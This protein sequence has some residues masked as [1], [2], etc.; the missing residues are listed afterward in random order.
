MPVRQPTI[1]FLS[2][3]GLAIAG[4]GSSASDHRPVPPGEDSPSFE[5]TVRPFLE[6][7]CLACHS[8]R[9]RKGGLDLE[10]YDS[11]E[12]VTAD[13]DRWEEV[14][15]KVG[16]GEMPPEDEEPRPEPAD[17]Q[18]LTAFVS[19]EIARADAARAADP[20]RVI[21][22]RLNRTEYNN[23]VRDLLGLDLH[24]ADAFPHDD[25]GYGFDNIGDVLSLSPILMEK[26]L[27]AAET[28]ART[29]I[30]GPEAQKPSL[31]KLP[32]LT[33]R[34]QDSPD[35]PA[36]Y[37]ATGLGLPNAVHATH[38]V[39][40]GG[41]YVVRFNLGGRRPVGSA[42]VRFAL[43]I[44]GVQ[45]AAESVDPEGGATFEPDHQEF[46]GRRLEFRVPLAAGEHWIA[47]TVLNLYE[48]LPPSYGGPVPSTRPIPPP[49]PRFK[50]K[51]PAN[52]VR[53]GS[54]ELI[55]PYAARTGPSAA[56]LEAVYTCGHVD[57]RHSGRCRTKI[58][59]SLARRAFRRPVTQAEVDRFTSIAL[60]G[61]RTNGTFEEGL[62]VA[63]QAIL[64]APD[65][66][67]RIERGEPVPAGRA[68]EAVP[69][70]PHELATRLAYFLWAS[71]PD[72]ALTAAADRRTL[73]DPAVLAQQVRRMLRDPR[74]AA[75][76]EHFGG[77]WLQVRA[78]ESTSPDRER[79]PDFDHYLRLSMRRETEL[80][81]D[82]IVREDRSVLDFL[83]GGYTFVNERLARHYGLEGVEGPQF[84]RVP[85]P[86]TGPRGGLL[87]H[88]SILTVSSYATRTSPVLRGKWILENLLATPPP[89]PP[90]DVPNLDEKAVGTAASLRQQLEAHRADPTCASCHKRMDPLGFGL[91]NFDAVGAW[92]TTD[93][94]F[95]VDASG[96]L[97]DGRS[98]SGPAELRR[99]L[100]ADQDAFVRA[101]AGKL[102]TY[103]LGR[104]LERSDRHRIRTIADAVA[105]DDYRFS[106]LVLGIVSSPAFQARRAD[107]SPA[108]A[109]AAGSDSSHTGS[110]P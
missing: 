16:A 31:V 37:D 70:T 58:V 104:G 8:S 20:G 64:V 5:T 45:V 73:R 34:V 41:E 11:I 72:E 78:L 90:P 60:A 35:V 81:F 99:I 83:D 1:V 13:A 38:R 17:V 106:S 80:F 39:T 76:A 21:T 49:S 84:R 88:A 50:G 97:P 15:R 108:V 43:W 89:E 109:A 63:I 25:S 67:F 87:G 94:A 101:L 92:R 36:A 57:G 24:P 3:A 86:P 59:A 102:M 22:R 71:P 77:Q 74:A 62:A 30:F 33:G 47:G 110:R 103:A 55:G 9:R 4:A 95:A 82:T 68:V 96:V 79:F 10:A 32:T 46:A 7:N 23:T 56:S 26:Y 51:V 2:L 91:E 100:R 98:F 12:K 19:R 85:L 27:A 53:V 75:L 65:F 61:E 42:P 52:A 44:D 105:R 14:I 48:G 18:A 28:L 66:L 107:P 69:L 93:G 29:A 40:V 54:L 6:E